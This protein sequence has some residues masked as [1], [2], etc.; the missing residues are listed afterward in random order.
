MQDESEF[1]KIRSVF[2]P[3]GFHGYHGNPKALVKDV[4][5][6][7]NQCGSH[8]LW[9]STV[10]GIAWRG[11]GAFFIGKVGQSFQAS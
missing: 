11:E 8:V 10:F 4:L 2:A 1:Y 5:S 9:S 7:V 6:S 3:R